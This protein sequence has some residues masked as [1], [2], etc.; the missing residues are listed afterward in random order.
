MSGDA[1]C[2]GCGQRA[3]CIEISERVVT[4]AE[5]IDA[6]EHVVGENRIDAEDGDLVAAIRRLVARVDKETARVDKETA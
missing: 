4:D 1:D 2:R 3:D 5:M 6:I